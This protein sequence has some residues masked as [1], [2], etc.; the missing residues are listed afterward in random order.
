MA[1]GDL[2]VLSDA[3]LMAALQ[4]ARAKQAP[5]PAPVN[6]G[7][8][9]GGWDPT[10]GMSMSDKVLSGIGRGMVHGVK[11]VGNLVGLVPDSTLEDMKG[12]DAPLLKTTSGQVGNLVGEAALTAPLGMGVGAAASKLPMVGSALA[13]AF[14]QGIIQGATQGVAT[15]DPGDRLSGGLVGGATGG[16]VG[17][18]TG[19]AGKLINGL[20]RTPEA[21]TLIDNGVFL[22]PGQMNPSGVWNRVEQMTGHVPGIGELVESSRDDAMHQ[23]QVAA[24][25]KGRA[26]G[27][28]P[29]KADSP[30]NMLQQAQD[31]YKPLYDQAKGF[32]VT[33]HIYR[34]PGQVAVPLDTTMHVAAHAPGVPAGLQQS[35][36]SWLQDRLTRLGRNPTSDDLLDLRSEIR[37]RGREA[38]LRS[39][40]DSTHV[41]T[42]AD[43]ADQGVTAALN[44]QLPGPA[45]QALQVA[46]SNYG[47]YKKLENAVAMSKDNVA[48]MT[49]SK[50][51]DAV[52]RGTPAPIYAT[53]GGG[54]LRDLSRAGSQVFQNRV[55]PTGV[56]VTG[57]GA[58]GGAAAGLGHLAGAVPASAAIGTAAAPA[59][60]MTLTP[61][62]RKFA[63][64]ATSPQ[65]NVQDLVSALSS[66]LGPNG[67]SAA[68]QLAARGA[69]GALAPYAPGVM[70]NAAVLATALAGAKKKDE[71]SEE[72]KR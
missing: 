36:N 54:P 24:M 72:A 58:L 51:A 37:Q 1:D 35:E 34:G 66:R 71:A 18:G 21:Q 2:S 53:G 9:V 45:R 4:A 65:L 23:W 41:A 56:T 20:K 33:P 7:T 52:K 67:A 61:T 50:L 14:P 46:D 48:E 47:N 69:T 29:I 26:P 8:P 16:A 30:A 27:S 68:K 32:P 70:T 43:R 11:S 22:T 31:S 49:P 28:P 64:G 25:N 55:P 44:S 17:L 40:N 10:D 15:A 13:G 62:G 19:I 63:A 57:L 5:P 42:I 6:N 39:D 3:D 12:I 59:A 60:W 38:K